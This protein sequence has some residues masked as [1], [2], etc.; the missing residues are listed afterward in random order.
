[1]C[2]ATLFFMLF[3]SVVQASEN[4]ITLYGIYETTIQD[5]KEY[6]NP[7]DYTEVSYSA[8]FTSP[9][10]KVFY[11]T[12][13]YDG[14]NSQGIRIWKIRFMPDKPGVWSYIVKNNQ[15]LSVRNGQFKVT[16]AIAYTGNRG[17]ISV[18]PDNPKYLIHSDGTPHYWVGGKWIAA[19]DYGPKEKSGQ[20]NKGFDNRVKLSYG[21]KT[22]LQL[23]NYLDLLE[24]FQ[25]NGLLLKIAL[26]PLENDKVS[27]DLD[28]IRRGEWIIN[29][30][31]KRGIYVQVNM[32][33]TWSRDKNQYFVH[34]MDGKKQLFDV[35]H[36]GNE[37]YKKNYLQ[38]LVSRFAAFANVY[39]ELGN[40]MEHNPN[41]GKCFIKQANEKYI[42]WIRQ[43]DPYDLPIGL[44]ENIWRATNVDI[45]FLHHANKLPGSSMLKPVIMNELVRYDF[46]Q[47]FP[48]K[49]WRKLFGQKLPRGLW[50][51]DAINNPELRFIFRKA[52]WQVFTHGG[53]G[54]SE[55]TWLN[56]D[57]NISQAA[58]NVMKDHSI[59][60]TLIKD[61]QSELNMTNP[62]Y[63]FITSEDA[64]IKISSRGNN[65]IIISYFDAG[66][67]AQI[68][69]NDISIKNINASYN[70]QWLNPSTGNKTAIQLLEKGN[71]IKLQ[72]P[73]FRE[74]IILLLKKVN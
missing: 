56:I 73:E 25:H 74:D 68:S 44:S 42:P 55:A 67:N 63:D 47:S 4:T 15:D 61:I 65:S 49:V 24:Q 38:Y 66:I 58:L 51:D 60:I 11:V 28:W 57:N 22:N 9:D 72:R 29:E 54:I 50:H 35:W 34:N 62:I 64:D 2:A 18:D 7:F 14:H 59:L 5:D 71:N 41:C 48:Q 46:S 13:F 39:W 20:A 17:H 43:F 45:G 52:F 30:A 26:Y 16:S 53:S 23:I 33:D 21:H 6:K 70:V 19:R 31:L 8:K 27:W 3:Y 36:A 1:M 40:E 69:S 12:G 10:S 32:F 37:H